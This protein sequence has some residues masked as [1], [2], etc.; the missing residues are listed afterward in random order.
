M[1]LPFL[2]VIGAAVA[3]R[4]YDKVAKLPVFRAVAPFEQVEFGSLWS[5]D[6]RA[7]TVFLRS[8]G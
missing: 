8:Y 3:L 6:E 5:E 7:V 4:P 2:A 1:R